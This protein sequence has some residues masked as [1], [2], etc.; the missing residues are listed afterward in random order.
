MR[1][2]LPEDLAAEAPGAAAA[3][4]PATG[5][6]QTSPAGKRLLCGL[7]GEEAALYLG[8]QICICRASTRQLASAPANRMQVACHLSA[9]PCTNVPC[10]HPTCAVAGGAAGGTAGRPSAGRPRERPDDL[11]PALMRYVQGGPRKKKNE[12]GQHTAFELY[13]IV[14]GSAQDC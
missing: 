6:R 4:A 8:S 5:G 9:A 11:L 1:V 10:L 13:G 3:G 12:V 14:P 7:A 2:G